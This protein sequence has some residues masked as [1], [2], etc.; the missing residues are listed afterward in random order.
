MMLS[1]SRTGAPRPQVAARAPTTSALTT[2]ALTVRRIGK[3]FPTGLTALRDVSFDVRDGG[4]TSVLGPSGC[5]KSTLLK[6]IAGLLPPSAGQLELHGRTV[7]A[8]P[9]GLIYV[10][11]Q[12]SKSLL[13]WKT[14]LGNVMFGARSPRAHQASATAVTR[15]DC[16]KYLELVGLAGHAHSYPAQLSGGM[17]QRVAI[18]RALVARPQVLLMDEPF[19]ALDAL[20]REGLQDLLLNLWKSVGLTVVFVT[21]DISEAIYLSD[22]IVVLAGTPATVAANIEVEVPRPRHQV[23]TRESPPFLSLRREL[24]RMVVGREE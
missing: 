12:Y 8:P 6:M 21:H 9:P 10:F 15:A 24:Y 2:S 5:G 22:N 19:S 7:S 16:M 18:A 14:V 20:T 1:A 3:T 23:S 4:F 17:Q 11:Q 13:P